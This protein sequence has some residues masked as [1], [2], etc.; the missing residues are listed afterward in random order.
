MWTAWQEDASLSFKYEEI[1]VNMQY[2]IN[3][4][5]SI[6]RNQTLKKFKYVDII[7][8]YFTLLN[9]ISKMSIKMIDY[10]SKNNYVKLVNNFK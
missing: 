7:K 6:G 2:L 5:V 4:D 9:N 10:L 8:L 1:T 3:Y